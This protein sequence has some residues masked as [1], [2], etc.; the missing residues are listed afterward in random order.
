MVFTDGSQSRG[1]SPLRTGA[2]WL[3]CDQTRHVASGKFAFGAATPFDAEMAALAVGLRKA[4]D[5]AGPQITTINIFADNKA[6]AQAILAAGDGPSQ[7]I[8]ILAS[9]T[10]RAFLE[11]SPQH[12]IVIWWCPSHCGIVQNEFVDQGAKDALD[13]PQPDFT[14]YSIARQRLTARAIHRWH[15]SIEDTSYRGEHNLARIQDLRKCGVSHIKQ[16]PIFQK[17]GKSNMDFARVARFLSGHFP[18]GEFRQRFNLEGARECACGQPLET[19]EHILYDCPLWVRSP[20]LHRPRHLSHAF[21]AVLILDEEDEQNRS[22]HPSFKQV[23]QFL[24]QNPMVATFE[25][26]ELLQKAAEDQQRGGGPTFSQALV[27]A[28]TTI[29]VALY[30]MYRDRHGSTSDFFKNYDASHLE[31]LTFIFI[32]YNIFLL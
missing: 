22:G 28:H 27:E 18:H 20:S 16:H 24:K 31:K 9:K 10:A 30:R 15:K 5:T 19:R 17:S 13:L 4:T 14:S 32:Y 1:T 11:R 21:R 26:A 2:A 29:K 12:K 3:V 6:A 7:M 23:Y 25:W 8:S